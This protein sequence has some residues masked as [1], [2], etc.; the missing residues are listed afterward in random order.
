MS[1]ELVPLQPRTVSRYTTWP[2]LIHRISRVT[3][4]DISK[5]YKPKKNRT[6]I[7]VALI[8]P[9]T[10]MWPYIWDNRY[11]TTSPSA[12]RTLIYLWAS[13]L[14]KNHK[15]LW[16]QGNKYFVFDHIG[17]WG[18]KRKQGLL[19]CDVIKK[20]YNVQLDRSKSKTIY[21][22]FQTHSQIIHICNMSFVS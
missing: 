3:H 4:L 21:W 18:H 13:L 20:A 6:I 19:E 12:M 9:R 10:M 8:M 2:T 16:I 15:I 17:L 5:L 14:Q 7:R 11:V 22:V 1:W